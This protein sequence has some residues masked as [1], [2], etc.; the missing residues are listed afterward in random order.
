MFIRLPPPG[1]APSV[2]PGAASAPPAPHGSA[3]K[4]AEKEQKDKNGPYNTQEHAE[5]MAKDETAMRE[6]T[7]EN[8]DKNQDHQDG[9]EAP[10]TIAA[11]LRARPGRHLSVIL[12]VLIAGI[13]IG[14]RII[15]A[16]SLFLSIAIRHIWIV[17][18]WRL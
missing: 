9:A 6:N 13:V 18:V 12:I 16:I 14:V 11:L 4:H 2:P 10:G 5:Y 17:L 15:R 3:S 1:A 7:L 8:A